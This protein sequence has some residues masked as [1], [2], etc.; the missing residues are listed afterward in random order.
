MIA[1]DRVQS[2]DDRQF[3][4]MLGDFGQVFADMNVGNVRRYRFELAAIGVFRFHVERVCLRRSTRH[5]QQNTVALLP[6]RFS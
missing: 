6:A 2:A 3:V 4:G 1:F 5:P